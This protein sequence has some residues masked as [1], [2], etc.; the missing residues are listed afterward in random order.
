MKASQLKFLKCQC[1]QTGTTVVFMPACSVGFSEQHY[2]PNSCF[3]FSIGPWLCQPSMSLSASQLSQ[4][5]RVLLGGVPGHCR[6]R[7]WCAQRSARPMLGRGWQFSLGWRRGRILHRVPMVHLT[8]GN[9]GSPVFWLGPRALHLCAPLWTCDLPSLQLRRLPQQKACMWSLELRLEG[10]SIWPTTT[11]TSGVVIFCSPVSIT[12]RIPAWQHVASEGFFSLLFLA[13]RLRECS[14]SSNQD[15]LLCCVYA[16]STVLC[17]LESEPF[18]FYSFGCFEWFFPEEPY[19]ST[20]SIQ[21]LEFFL[22][23]GFE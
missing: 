17:L 3:F 20:F 6:K 7:V 21:A 19:P 13:P 2:I 10:V 14:Y 4:G 18:S 11:A 9:G 8:R 22:S 5:W 12:P 1:T 16:C 23:L 15:R